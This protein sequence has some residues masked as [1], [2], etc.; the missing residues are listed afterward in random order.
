MRSGGAPAE[1]HR[2][3]DAATELDVAAGEGALLARWSTA[4]QPALATDGRLEL[5]GA[6]HPL[7]IPAVRAASART[8]TRRDDGR[9]AK[10]RCRSTSC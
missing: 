7:L 4:S 6:R 2:T 8:Q 10:A 9:G 5:R 3:L 1:L